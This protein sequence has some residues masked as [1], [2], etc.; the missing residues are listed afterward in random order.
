MKRAALFFLLFV[1]FHAASLDAQYAAGILAGPNLSTQSI[2]ANDVSYSMGLGYQLGFFA[3]WESENYD[4]QPELYFS[5]QN[6]AV[7]FEDQTLY[8]RF[9][10]LMIPLLFRYHLNEN[11]RLMAGPQLGIL[12]CARSNFHPVTR[13]PYREQV[14]STAYRGSD[15]S[16]GLGAGWEAGNGLI[17]D[18][19]YNLGLT[20]ISNYEG[21]P[22]T[23]N[24]F[25]ELRIAYLFLMKEGEE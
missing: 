25:L 23:R 19:K 2:D 24:R 12:L 13:E 8:S 7:Q 16:F 11:F 21:V 6:A 18:L 4:I 15:F 1:L 17:V 3:R 5:Q 22:A 9:R 10:Y 20:D 14:Y